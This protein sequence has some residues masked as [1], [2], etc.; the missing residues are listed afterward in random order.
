MSLRDRL[1][2]LPQ[3]LAPQHLLSRAVRWATRQ[4]WSTRLIAPFCERFRVDMSEA[5][6][7]L[8]DYK[9]FNDFFT[10]H[11][12][13]GARPIAAGPGHLV[14]PA[15]GAISQFGPVQDGQLLQAKGHEFS[16]AALLGGLADETQP[17]TRGHFITVYLSPRDYHRVHA[18]FDF[19]ARELRF[20][21]GALFSVNDRTARSVP[22]LYARNERLVLLGNSPWGPAAFV[23][24]GAMLV[25]S[26]T[27]E[28]FELDPIALSAQR[29][30]QQPLQPSLS[31]PQGAEVGRFNMGS[32]VI[33]VLPP[34]APVWRNGLQPGI[35]VRMGELLAA[36]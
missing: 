24:V 17:L 7:P 18:P 1:L 33:L 21:P 28:G 3:Y 26:M 31:F 8:H 12:R 22:D 5:A 25:S 13:E 10:R 23:M 34:G 32:T 20:I 14:C 15:D 9:S 27:L 16:L 6:R 4:S 11:L 19:Q 2:V 35:K 36:D 29:L 30:H